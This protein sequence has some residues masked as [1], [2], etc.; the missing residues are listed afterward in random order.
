[1]I[2]NNESFIYIKNRFTFKNLGLS[3]CIFY[4]SKFLTKFFNINK[5]MLIKK[6]YN[7]TYFKNFYY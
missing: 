4:F 7:K 1:M 3:D 5:V 6:S 2:T